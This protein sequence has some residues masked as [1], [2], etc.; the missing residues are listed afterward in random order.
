MIE[1]DDVCRLVEHVWGLV[2]GLGA[3][4][5]PDA[6]GETGPAMHVPVRGAWEGYV[7]VSCDRELARLAAARLFGVAS[8]TVTDDQTNDALGELTNIIGGNLKGLLPGSS[9]LGLRGSSR[10]ACPPR[11]GRAWPTPPSD[12][13]ACPS[14][15]PCSAAPPPSRPGRNRG[16]LRTFSGP[17]AALDRHRVSDHDGRAYANRD[18]VPRAPRAGR[19]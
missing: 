15:S 9:S 12:A 17:R 18:R 11:P 16:H 19:S 14:R 6:P 10:R 4:A 5:A 3:E 2:V 1:R 7:V 8:K 13:R